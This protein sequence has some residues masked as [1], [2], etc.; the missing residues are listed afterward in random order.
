MLNSS[1]SKKSIHPMGEEVK[2]DYIDTVCRRIEVE[3]DEK[4]CNSDYGQAVYF[5]QFL[6]ITGLYESWRKDMP[7]NLKSPNAPRK[8]DVC[9]TALPGA[10]TGQSRYA[11]ITSIRGDAILKECFDIQNIVSEDSL[12]RNLSKMDPEASRHWMWRHIKA[13]YEPLLIEPYILDIDVTVKTLYGHQEFAVPGYNPTKPGRPSHTYH[14]CFIGNL[15]LILNV[16]VLAGNQTA[17]KYS[18][19]GLWELLD[20]LSCENKPSF[21]RGD[22]SYGNEECMLGCEDRQM[23]YLFKLKKSNKIKM[24]IK[25]LTYHS[26]NWEKAGHGWE[27]IEKQICL[28]GGV[29]PGE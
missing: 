6:K 23:S 19:T 10:L 11:H 26:E 17:G 25:E 22:V 20:S 18:S 7:L 13:S 5:A 2:R 24:L 16:D 8:E 12:R 28:P 14:T 3:W 1:V 29:I 27:G 15:R 9:G 4:A 21:V